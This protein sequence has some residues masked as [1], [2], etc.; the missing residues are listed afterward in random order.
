L[1]YWTEDSVE[2]V[3]HEST[4]PYAASKN[5]G[6]LK[7]GDEVWIVSWKSGKLFLIGGLTV[8]EIVRR[9]LAQRRLGRTDLWPGEFYAI[10]KGTPRPV[11]REINSI[12]PSI[13]F[14]SPKERLSA[15]VNRWPQELQ[16]I[17]TLLPASAEILR[18]EYQKT[19]N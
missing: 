5:F 18:Q 10:P 7:A 13:R 2:R 8:A 4:I 3:L 15:N 19:F 11:K 17:R 14:R 9:D 1:V 16:Q 6:K 12:A